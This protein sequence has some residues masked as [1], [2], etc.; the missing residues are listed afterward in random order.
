MTIAYGEPSTGLDSAATRRAVRAERA[1][2]NRWRRLVRARLDLL[3]ASY[4]PPEAIGE[5]TWDVLP[6]HA[7]VPVVE[8]LRTAVCR[9][10]AEDRVGAMHRLRELDR[11]LA[12]Y[13]ARLD[14][15]E[16]KTTERLVMR[17][18]LDELERSA[19]EG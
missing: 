3:V 2:V 10:P 1:T 7:D 15:A 18:V 19:E 4:A 16:E 5:L 17:L 8:E 11:R 6:A 9:D 13:A 14:T 12:T